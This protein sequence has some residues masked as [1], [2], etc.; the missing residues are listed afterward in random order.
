M[1]ENICIIMARGGSKRIPHKNIRQLGGAPL[2]SWPIRTA[3][4]S[5]IFKHILI[6]TEDQKIAEAAQ[7][8]GAEFPFARPTEFANDYATTTDVLRAVLHQWQQ[9]SG[10]LPD[11]CCCLYGTSIFI[12]EKH[13]QQSR[14]LLDS[15]DLVMAVSEYPHPIQRALKMDIHGDFQYLHPEFVKTRTQDCPKTFYDI[16][17]FYYFSSAAFFEHGAESF[18]PLHQKAIIVPRTCAVDIDTD[19]DWAWAEILAQYHRLT[20]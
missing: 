8:A 19:E 6:S 1:S 3:V 12:Q 5:G 17:L 20:K 14:R 4:A 10:N 7:A 11:Y 16:G 9:F 18:I 2:V 13:L 15:A